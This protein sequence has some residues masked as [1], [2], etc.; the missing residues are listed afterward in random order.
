MSMACRKEMRHAYEIVFEKSGGKRLL[1]RRMC[2]CRI[3]K[4]IVKKRG[5]SGLNW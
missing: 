4:L 3:I 1:G 5:V 2:R